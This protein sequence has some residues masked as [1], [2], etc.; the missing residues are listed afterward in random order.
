MRFL[1]FD[2]SA[3][4]RIEKKKKTKKKKSLEVSEQEALVP[5]DD[6]I[7]YVVTMLIFQI[8]KL[9]QVKNGLTTSSFSSLFE[10]A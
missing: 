5:Q 1:I 7:C 4:G 6:V 3:G 2:R 9:F 10:N 8:K